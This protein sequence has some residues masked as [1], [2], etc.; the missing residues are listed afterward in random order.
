M[1]RRC[2]Q[3][4]GDAV[5]EPTETGAVDT[6]E[7][8]KVLPCSHYRRDP[9]Q[10]QL[11]PGP[12]T[13]TAPKP[14]SWSSPAPATR[15]LPRHRTARAWLELAAITTGPV[16][17]GMTKSNKPSGR[18]LHP[19]SINTLVQAAIAQSGIDPSPYSAHSLGL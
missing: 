2:P 7:Y 10:V 15:P 17:Q 6:G 9:S 13:S 3:P 11:C 4:P 18:P 8:R 12:R 1:V 19:E 16:F 5:D 14:N